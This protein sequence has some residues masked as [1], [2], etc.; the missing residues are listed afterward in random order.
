MESS[1]ALII[2]VHM[3]S[4]VHLEYGPTIHCMTVAHVEDVCMFWDVG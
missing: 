1:R 3:E 2:S 4:D